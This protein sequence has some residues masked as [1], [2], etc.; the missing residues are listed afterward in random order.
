VSDRGFDLTGW[1]L[2]IAPGI[3]G[4]G[5]TSVGHGRNPEGYNEGRIAT[6]A[7]PSTAALLALGLL[8]IGIRRRCAWIQ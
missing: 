1:V 5:R 6:I 2:T 3:S 4:H 7:E 8:G